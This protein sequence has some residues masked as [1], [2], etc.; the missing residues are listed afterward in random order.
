MLQVKSYQPGSLKWLD[1][2]VEI[3]LFTDRRADAD[4]EIIDGSNDRRGHWGDMFLVNESL[5]SK[6]WLLKRKTLTN[7]VVNKARG[8]CEQATQHLVDDGWLKS[9][10]VITERQGK[11]LLAIQIKGQL[12]DGRDWSKQLE[13]GVNNGN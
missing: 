5:G 10:K 1:Q 9:V 3:S 6:L 4:E 12:P 7:D 8:Y 2:A 11:D 13:L